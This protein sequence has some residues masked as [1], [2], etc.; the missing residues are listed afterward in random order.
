MWA[1]KGNIQWPKADKRTELK[2]LVM[3]MEGTDTSILSVFETFW[4]EILIFLL[5]HVE[6]MSAC[7]GRR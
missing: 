6:F 7:G 2:D 3:R 5:D 4:E 1:N